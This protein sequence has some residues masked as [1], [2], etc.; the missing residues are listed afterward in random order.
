MFSRHYNSF[1]C[2]LLTD[3]VMKTEYKMLFISF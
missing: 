3:L 1:T 2:V